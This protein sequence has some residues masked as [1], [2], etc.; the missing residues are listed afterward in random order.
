MNVEL[1]VNADTDIKRV[2]KSGQIS[3]GK[4]LAGQYYRE[5]RQEDGSIVLVPVV[6]ISKS[7][8]SVRDE[9]K[10]RKAVAWAAKNPAKESNLDA[11]AVKTKKKSGAGSRHGR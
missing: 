10:I 4:Q 5:E 1:S 6:V 7:H 3:V 9:G 8:W 11:L 2:G